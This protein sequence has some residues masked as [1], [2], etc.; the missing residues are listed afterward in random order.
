MENNELFQTIEQLKSTLSEISSAR[1]QVEKTV[2]SSTDLQKVVEDY[3]ASVKTLCVG[4]NAWNDSLGDFG[5]DL[6]ERYE[7]AISKL[8]T[9]CSEI[10]TTFHTD[11][12]KIA[13]VFKTQTEDTISKFE[14]QNN[15]L[16]DKVK[17]LGVLRDEI[18][19]AIAEIAPIKESLSQ[20]SKELKESQKEQDIV[21]DDIRQ[22]AT[23]I[24]ATIKGYTD[25]IVEKLETINQGLKT[26]LENTNTKID[27]LNEKADY[28][29]S[30]SS[31][32][33]SVLQSSTTS[34]TSA[35]ATSKK[36]TAKSITINRWIIIIGIIMLAVLQ[37]FL[38]YGG[39][40]LF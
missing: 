6:R 13:T 7:K 19:T 1:E 21:L 8:I 35:I 14:K 26:I 5:N 32:I 36:E 25:A 24:P 28:L 3:V 38:K 29:K 2:K 39:H 30:V 10:I 12:G 31:Q 27:L 9:S 4:L 18:K 15:T 37:V 23:N 17:E 34:I 11:V 33:L 16:S 20:L 22:K 40:R